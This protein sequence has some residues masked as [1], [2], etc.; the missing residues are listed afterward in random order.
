MS[1]AILTAFMFARQMQMS[2]VQPSIPHLIMALAD[3]LLQRES[4]IL[5][6][7]ARIQALQMCLSLKAKQALT[8]AD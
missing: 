6:P 5:M 1:E 7:L 3:F 2:F 4:P 8:V